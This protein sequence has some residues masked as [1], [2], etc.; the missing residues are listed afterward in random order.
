M[1]EGTD[2]IVR[3]AS[4]SFTH[5]HVIYVPKFR[6]GSSR[7]GEFTYVADNGEIAFKLFAGPPRWRWWRA[8]RFVRRTIQGHRRL[9]H[10]TGLMIR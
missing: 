6:M 2:Y 7:D 10:E 5:V 3:I 8:R 1:V 9:I 4:S